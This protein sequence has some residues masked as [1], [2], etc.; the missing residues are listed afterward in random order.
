MKAQARVR[1]D[2]AFSTPFEHPI[3]SFERRS[4]AS[5]LMVSG[6]SGN[7]DKLSDN[8]HITLSKMHYARRHGYKY[9]HQLSDQF[10]PYFPQNLFEVTGYRP[11]SRSLSPKTYTHAYI[12]A[13]ARIYTYFEFIKMVHS[14]I[15]KF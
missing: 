3:D 11:S 10:E 4:R 8:M 13:Y 7:A 2:S 5:I 6:S 9:I 1:F 15:M 14:N 12:H